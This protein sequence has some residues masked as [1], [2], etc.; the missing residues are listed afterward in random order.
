MVHLP[1][2]AFLGRHGD[3]TRS[4]STEPRQRLCCQLFA[5]V[6]ADARNED[7]WDACRPPSTPSH[8]FDLL[9]G[10]SMGNEG[11]RTSMLRVLERFDDHKPIVERHIREHGRTVGHL[12][13]LEAGCGRGWPFH[14]P[15][16]PMTLIG[17]DTDRDALAA[18]QE[19]GDLD[20]AILGD[21]HD[22]SIPD[23]SFDIIYCRFVLEHIRG[24]EVVLDR[25]RAWLK[26]NGLMILIFPDRDSVYSFF[27]R[28]TPHVFHVMFKKYIAGEKMAGAPGY[29][30]YPTY[31]EKVT[32]RKGFLSFCK[33][34]KLRVDEEC[35]MNVSRL[36]PVFYH[37]CRFVEMLSLGALSGG[38]VNLVYVVSKNDAGRE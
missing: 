6:H 27:T 19:A 28:L 24:A 36:P 9:S 2:V 11:E 21:L 18:R 17:V 34:R 7:A 10:W 5:L 23:A 30:P 20:E 26:P 29:G 38:H 16:T 22:V 8:C 12:R 4:T 35:A 13:V 37:F 3:A 14:L 33:I 32:A 1:C 15:D 25:F 31:N